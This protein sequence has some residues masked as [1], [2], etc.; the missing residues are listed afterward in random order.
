MCPQNAD[1]KPAGQ[2]GINGLSILQ[3]IEVRKMTTFKT[4]RRVAALS[5]V[6]SLLTIGSAFGV[7]FAEDSPAPP[8]PTPVTPPST[9]NPPSSPVPLPGGGA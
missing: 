5:V 6:G 4:C 1:V 8:V 2:I 3:R 7:A 9:D